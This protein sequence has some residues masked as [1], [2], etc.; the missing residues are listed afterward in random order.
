MH[1]IMEM[2]PEASSLARMAEAALTGG[3]GNAAIGLRREQVGK[4]LEGSQQLL[5]KYGSTEPEPRGHIRVTPPVEI[6]AFSERRL[7][8]RVVENQPLIIIQATDP[9]TKTEHMLVGITAGVDDPDIINHRS[10]A[11]SGL[12]VVGA[13]D[14]LDYIAYQLDARARFERAIRIMDAFENDP[15]IRAMQRPYDRPRLQ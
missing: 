6:L 3:D 9:G 15:E 1:N 12:E 14:A 2:I 7:L 5:I 10:Q 4:F 8:V 11:A 13:L